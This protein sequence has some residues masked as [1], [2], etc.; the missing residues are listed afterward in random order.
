MMC[1]WR[2]KGNNFITTIFDENWIGQ[3]FE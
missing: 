3:R 2:K 1:L